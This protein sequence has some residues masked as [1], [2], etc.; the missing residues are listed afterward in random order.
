MQVLSLALLS[1]LRVWCCHELWCRSQ[2]WLG[3]CVL[4]YRP[5]A[6]APIQPLTWELPYAVGVALKK[7]KGQTEEREVEMEDVEGGKEV[8]CH[9]LEKITLVSVGHISLH[10]MVYI[11]RSRNCTTPAVFYVAFLLVSVL[12]SACP[13]GAK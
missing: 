13:R 11:K 9:H 5:A 4:W 8:Q 7:K 10:F 6:V 12:A 3:S 2:I 1:G